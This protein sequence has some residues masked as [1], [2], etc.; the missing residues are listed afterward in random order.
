MIP[1]GGHFR[2]YPSEG[3]RP[4]RGSEIPLIGS[5]LAR[6]GLVCPF[7]TGLPLQYSS[8]TIGDA[9][10]VYTDSAIFS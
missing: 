9:R 6:L 1:T 5:I 7:S 2:R 10:A 8:L 4:T 3:L